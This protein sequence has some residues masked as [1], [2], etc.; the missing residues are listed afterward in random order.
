MKLTIKLIVA[1]VSLTLTTNAQN[2]AIDPRQLNKRGCATE[3]P[4]AEWDAWFNK[5]VEEYKQNNPS[6]KNIS[7]ITIP[8]VVH[9]IH[10]GQSVGIFPN[11]SQN[12][13]KSQ[14]AVL[15][16][17]FAG[18]GMNSSLLAQTGFSTVGAADC[19]ITF[20]LA[21]NDPDGGPLAEPGIH[22]V[23]Y[24]SEGW[25]NPVSATDLNSF[26][27]LMDG[28][29]KANTIWDPTRYFNIW[30]SDVHSNVG[31]LGYATFPGGTNLTGLPATGNSADDGIWVW[32]RSFG[33][34]GI[35]QYPYNFGRTAT[36]ETGHW[37]GLRHIGGDG[38]NNPNGDCGATDYCNDTP[39]Q[40][41]GYSSGQYGQNFGGPSYPLHVN[42]C[43][44]PYGDMF[45]NFMDY[46]D[47]AFN[48]MFT[49]DQNARIQTALLEG[50]Y[51]NG[52]NESAQQLC[53]GIPVADFYI[54]T[55]L[56]TQQE[57]QPYN[58]TN[59]SSPTYTW[60]T[61]PSTGVVFTPDE[62]DAAPTI[63]F[64]SSGV[65]TIQLSSSNNAGI[66]KSS[67][68]VQLM[69]CTGMKAENKNAAA[70]VIFPNPG[71]GTF[72]LKT[73]QEPLQT[74]MSVRVNN[75]LGQLLYSKEEPWSPAVNLNLEHLPAGIYSVNIGLDK[76]TIVK[77]L[78]I[79]K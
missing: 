45:M 47:D 59:G 10:G 67:T 8:V 79:T 37:L 21:Q 11:I 20:C 69:D 14:I 32:A 41:G 48:Y 42:V 52:L 30:V 49:P 38:N 25:S 15:N 12:Q 74:T 1:A 75:S 27:I 4:T 2:K 29:I 13:I 35:L 77:R 72:T 31:I 19:N 3:V 54:D 68:V 23:N 55:L 9:V 51:R 43:S 56:C 18:T 61:T 57:M 6:H 64:P 78:V 26:K 39:S 60:V 66:T 28:T 24:V 76:E 53:A 16:K 50:Y 46:T 36:H 65:Y 63:N 17:D 40:K 70:V 58:Y 62:F 33:S 5:K 34:T 73:G 7:S 71:K 22:R 44:S